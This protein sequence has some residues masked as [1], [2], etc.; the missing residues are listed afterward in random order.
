M[1]WQPMVFLVV[2]LLFVMHVIMADSADKEFLAGWAL[3]GTSS[4]VMF[5]AVSGVD[6]RDFIDL[7]DFI[8]V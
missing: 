2:N 7:G 4:V 3:K 8:V 5:A 6:L 1:S